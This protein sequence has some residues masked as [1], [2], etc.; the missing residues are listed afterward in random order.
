MRKQP[1]GSVVSRVIWRMV[2]TMMLALVV[3]KEANI[4]GNDL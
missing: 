3:K 4:N 2:W 1:S